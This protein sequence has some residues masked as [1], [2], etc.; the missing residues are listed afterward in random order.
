MVDFPNVNNLSL[1]HTAAGFT[2]ESNCL[3]RFNRDAHVVRDGNIGAPR[4]GKLDVLKRDASRNFLRYNAFIRQCIN[5]GFAIN[6]FENI[7]GG[8]FGFR[9]VRRKRRNL[10]SSCIIALAYLASRHCSKDDGRHDG[11]HLQKVV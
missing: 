1:K 9:H 3:A 4:V 8:C 6:D 2:N 10:A 11:I 7:H 5:L